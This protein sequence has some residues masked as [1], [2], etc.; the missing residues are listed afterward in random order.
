MA[1]LNVPL[2]CIQTTISSV[3]G[4]ETMSWYNPA[5]FPVVPPSP[6]PAPVQV[7]YR[8]RIIMSVDVQTQSAYSTR[9]PGIYNGQDITVGQWIANL[10]TG[11]A[12]QIITIEAKSEVSITAIVQD[13]YRYNT[14]RDPS[15]AG[16]GAPNSGTYVVFNIGEAGVPEIDPVPPGGVSSI[17]GINIQ[18]RFQYINLQYDYP[19]YQAGNSFAY[20]DTIAADPTH[21]GFSL[22]D[23]TNRMV[24]GRVT[25][26]SDTIPGWFTINPVQKIVDDLDYLPGDVGD[27]IY[28]SLFVPGGITTDPGGS[29]L[30][31]KLRN[32]TSSVSYST[33]SGPTTANNVF[34]LNGEDVTVQYPGGIADV[35][36]A[37]NLITPLT[38]VTASM[39][40]TPSSVQTTEAQYYGEPALWVTGG[41]YATATINGVLVTFN[42]A[43]TDPEYTDYAR[44]A[45]MA[46]VINAAGIPNIIAST[47][48]LLV[49]MLT[50][51]AGG[52]ITIVNDTSDIHGVAFAGTNSGSGLVTFTPASS[53]HLI[54]F[55]ALDA[56]AI[57]FLDVIGSPVED[58]GLISV[59][60]GVKACGLYIEEG[61]RTATLT[62][63]TTLTQ[64]ATMH[65][66]I[67]DQ[68]YVMDSNDGQGNNVG[69][70]SLWLYNGDPLPGGWVQT[71]NQDSASTD[72]KSL[73]YSLLTTSPS[74]I[75]IGTIST[76]RRVSLITVEVITPFNSP[77]ASLSIG[78]SINNPPAPP[79]P[80]VDTSGLMITG[81]IDLTIT[82][83]YTTTTDILFGIDTVDGDVE[84]TSTFHNNGASLGKAQIIVSYV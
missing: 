57:N 71:S 63:V 73:E 48:S 34:Q 61:L 68:A 45:D 29:E 18:S 31:I 59:E 50:N 4:T 1:F 33:A 14:F 60:N 28:A 58:F 8:W 38:G 44:A 26:I 19:L 21:H 47:P 53:T 40:L 41:P 54:K 3:I 69:E 55:I 62:V 77:T 22:S 65:P 66:L 37:S 35:I 39:V 13:I 42:V 36:I 24:V 15:G 10:T 74:A 9:A 5:Q 79:L 78:Y 49:L 46:T 84:I 52:S 70:W 43:S 56:R 20:N 23:S 12:W 7:S 64:L 30:Y 2:K 82:G 6:Q 25:S 51:S 27:I 16:N 75:S 32:N 76:G 80:A 17:F 83:T 67:G 11:Q 72:A 81:L